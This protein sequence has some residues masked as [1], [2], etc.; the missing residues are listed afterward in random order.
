MECSSVTNL[1]LGIGIV[2]ISILIRHLRFVVRKRKRRKLICIVE[3]TNRGFLCNKYAQWEWMTTGH[4]GVIMQKKH[5]RTHTRAFLQRPMTLESFKSL[6]YLL[7][8]GDISLI[9]RLRSNFNGSPCLLTKFSA[10]FYYRFLMASFQASSVSIH[11]WYFFYYVDVSTA[12]LS[13]LP[14]WTSFFMPKQKNK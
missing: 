8:L 6:H 3:I 13:G 10:L 7:K 1:L 9:W 11:T 4:F 12:I 2:I 14:W 5:T